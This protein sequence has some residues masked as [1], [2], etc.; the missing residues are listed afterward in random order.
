VILLFPRPLRRKYLTTS[1]CSN[2]SMTT[3]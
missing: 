3:P 1:L 2:S